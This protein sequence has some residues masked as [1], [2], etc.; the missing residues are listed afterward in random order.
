MCAGSMERWSVS[1]PEVKKPCSLAAS[2]MPE[3]PAAANAKMYCAPCAAWPRASSLA[4]RRVVEA[5]APG[6]EDLRV[7]VD[8][9]DARLEADVPAADEGQVH[10][11]H[12]ADDVGLREALVL[13]RRE[14]PE[15]GAQQVGALVL[16]EHEAAHVGAVDGRVHERPLLVGELRRELGDGVHGVE[17]VGHDEVVAVLDGGAQVVLELADVGRL[18]DVGLDAELVP[19]RRRGRSG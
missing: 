10:G 1:T 12:G 15:D 19:P 13:A 8:G 7:R 9:L 11:A 3:L 2:K 17:G 4:P 14:E 6:L 18:D 16:P 5:G